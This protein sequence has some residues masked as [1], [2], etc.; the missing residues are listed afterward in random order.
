M[1][2]NFSNKDI[3]VFLEEIDFLIADGYGSGFPLYLKK[4]KVIINKFI[5]LFTQTMENS[6]FEYKQLK[7]SQLIFLK[8]FQ[9]L[10]NGINDYTGEVIDFEDKIISSDPL[11]QTLNY[12]RQGYVNILS[13]SSIYREKSKG[14][15]PLFKDRYIFPVI[16]ID[17]RIEPI[18]YLHNIEQL[19]KIYRSFYKKIGL[20]FL[21]LEGFEVRKYADKELYF[22]GHLD[23]EFTKLGMIYKLSKNFNANYQITNSDILLNSGLSGKTLFLSIKN[24]SEF[25]GKFAIPPRICE[26]LLYIFAKDDSYQ[27]FFSDILLKYN[28][29]C[30]V[31]LSEKHFYKKWKKSEAFYYIYMKDERY[32][33]IEKNGQIHSFISEDKVIQFIE[34]NLKYLEKGAFEY[35]REKLYSNLKNNTFEL[36]EEC[37]TKEFYGLVQEEKDSYCLKCGKTIH[38]KIFQS[39]SRFY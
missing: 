25:Y 28:D 1:A 38:K 12:A 6:N 15:I 7:V 22:L 20:Y 21:F 13:V 39:N 33:L 17:Q 37:Y 18:N 27:I 8:D 35:S 2:K 3:I 34:N 23:N 4:G 31:G 16:Q 11:S 9:K 29:S 26:K 24:F 14:L 30:Q 5:S 36:C 19:K 10:Y 32:E